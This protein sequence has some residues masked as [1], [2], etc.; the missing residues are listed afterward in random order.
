M[1]ELYRRAFDHSG[2]VVAPE[3]VAYL[4]DRAARGFNLIELMIVVAIV[5]LVLAILIAVGVVMSFAASP[6]V[7]SV[8]DGLPSWRAC[9][10]S[11]T[12]TRSLRSR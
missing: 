8:S 12:T 3:V 11:S 6:A 10:T 5:G 2:A 1:A 4:A 9:C 7:S